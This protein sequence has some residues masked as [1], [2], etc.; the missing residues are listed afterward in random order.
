[1][2]ISEA[3]SVAGRSRSVTWFEPCSRR[4]RAEAKA[5]V[6]APPVMTALPG[7][8]KRA[9]ARSSH[10]RL[11]G[12]GCNGAVSGDKAVERVIVGMFRAE[13]SARA[14]CITKASAISLGFWPSNLV[15]NCSGA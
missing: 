8:A 15:E 11:D 13:R 3:F 2:A 7:Q 14:S 4:A 5:S 10:D 9:F 1:M 6:P 12:R